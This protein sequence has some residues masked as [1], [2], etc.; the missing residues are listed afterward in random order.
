M[1]LKSQRSLLGRSFIPTIY[2]K[3]G[4]RSKIISFFSFP[5]NAGKKLKFSGSYKMSGTAMPQTRP[6]TT[7]AVGTQEMVNQ[8]FKSEDDVL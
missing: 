6:D 1:L 2:V 7:T 8:A 3:L 4:L 5:G